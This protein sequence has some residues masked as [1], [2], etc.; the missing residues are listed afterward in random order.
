MNKT[1]L[2]FKH[3][4]LNTIK[5]AS[6][7]V[8]TLIVPALALLGIGVFELVTAMTET[9]E[10]EKYAV[11]YVDEV[12]IFTDQTEL[13]SIQLVP[14]PIREDA[15]QALLNQEVTEYFVIPE[16]YTSAGTIRRFPL[17]KE[18][19]APEH[20]ID[21][22]KSFLTINLTKDKL[23]EDLIGLIVSPLKYE[24]TRVTD[25]GSAE[26]GQISYGN[27]IIP[28]I[29]SMLMA[30]TLMTCS[31]SLITSLGEEKE[32]RLIEVLFSSVSIRQLLTGKILALGSTGLIQVLIW[33][34]SA[35]ILLNLA[36]STFGG[37]ISTIQIPGNFLL[38]G[39][40]YFLLG[41]LLFAVLSV[42]VGGI[43]ANAQEGGNISLFYILFG[44]VPIWFFALLMAMPNSFIWVVLTI[45][46]ITAPVQT[47][48][49]LGVSEVPLWQILTSIG[50]LGL[51]I[52]V[53]LFL[54][55]KTFRAHMLMYGKKP[56]I[57]E[58]MR[59]LKES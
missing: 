55:I 17:E 19:M 59:N 38:L 51:S 42:G 44:F 31:Y 56:G 45:F 23:D 28:G 57:K 47:M 15:N 32:S 54:S 8:M 35:P 49:R 5:K 12:G 46:P 41:Y 11:G 6:F 13:G 37:F 1:Y 30:L 14:F 43:S 16:D 34:I 22:I 18:M 50:V 26:A 9:V 20:T 27:F 36:S 21:V 33:L 3:E 7:I 25:T 4:F 29:F 58:F 24:V 53:G 39:I 40:I 10:N 48:L 2:I 52:I